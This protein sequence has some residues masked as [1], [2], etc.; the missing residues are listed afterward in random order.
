MGSGEAAHYELQLTVNE[1]DLDVLQHVNNIT[2]LKWVQQIAEEHWKSRA[3]KSDQESSIWV[4]LSHFIKYKHPAFLNDR[5]KIR[6]YV[7]ETKGPRSVRHVEIFRGQTLLAKAAT[8]WC[9]LDV[10]TRRPKRITNELLNFF[11]A[12]EET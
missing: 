9:L 10:T 8:E 12:D 4:V 11:E 5:I 2:Y 6:T 1:A 7:G 3:T